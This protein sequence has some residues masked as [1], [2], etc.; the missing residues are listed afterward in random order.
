MLSRLFGDGCDSDNVTIICFNTHPARNNAAAGYLGAIHLIYV[1]IELKRLKNVL[2][3]TTERFQ[4][5]LK[6]KLIK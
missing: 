1:L 2:T 5:D 4:P 3:D 6:V